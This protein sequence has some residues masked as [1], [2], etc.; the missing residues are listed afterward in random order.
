MP[1]SCS[2]KINVTL[3]HAT[4]LFYHHLGYSLLHRSSASHWVVRENLTGCLSSVG[5]GIILRFKNIQVGSLFIWFFYPSWKQFGFA[6]LHENLFK[7]TLEVTTHRPYR[8]LLFKPFWSERDLRETTTPWQLTLSP[9][10]YL[11]Q[12]NLFLRPT[13]ALTLCYSSISSQL[14]WK[15]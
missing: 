5:C 14:S 9:S 6:T 7:H 3:H 1:M 2:Q 4:T 13:T 15:F 12:W 8:H 10:L 11:S